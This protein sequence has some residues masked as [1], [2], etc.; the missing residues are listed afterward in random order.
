VH[1]FWFIKQD[2]GE[3]TDMHAASITF[4]CHTQQEVQTIF[5]IVG[6]AP[7]KR[8]ST[9]VAKRSWSVY[10]CLDV[11]LRSRRWPRYLRIK[12]FQGKYSFFVNFLYTLYKV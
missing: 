10:A 2:C 9:N 7:N 5:A 11:L 6:Y 8:V 1:V 3:W 12:H 4:A